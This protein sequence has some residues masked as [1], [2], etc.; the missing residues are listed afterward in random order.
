[1]ICQLIQTIT[2]KLCQLLWQN[3]R[4]CV[5]A[6][7]H[8][9][10]HT[11][12]HPPTYCNLTRQLP[13]NVEMSICHFRDTVTHTLTWTLTLTHTHTEPHSLS[14]SYLMH[15][16]TSLK[17]IIVPGRKRLSTGYESHR[18]HSHIHHACADVCYNWRSIPPVAC[19]RWFPVSLLFKKL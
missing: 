12:T 6:R 5:Y 13:F 15:P 19:G 17:L 10:T 16:I 11:Q 18:L 4:T 1:M 9:R 8:A 14:C 7:T 2:V 3:T